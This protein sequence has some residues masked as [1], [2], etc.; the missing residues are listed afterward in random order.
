[1]KNPCGDEAI[2]VLGR[3]GL[4]RE[5]KK[6][7]RPAASLRE[8]GSGSFR[9]GNDLKVAVSAED[10]GADHGVNPVHNEKWT[11]NA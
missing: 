11:Q 9:G 3:K 4:Q 8:S 10:P 7:G 2:P 1:L 6:K 5:K